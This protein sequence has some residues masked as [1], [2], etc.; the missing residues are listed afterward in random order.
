M[1]S[2]TAV[3]SLM[4]KLLKEVGFVQCP[5]EGVLQWSFSILNNLVMTELSNGIHNHL[6]PQEPAAGACLFGSHG[7]T[8]AGFE[9]VEEPVPLQP[10]LP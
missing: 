9:E 10:K 7:D 3:Q 8:V 1:V 5:A 4:D 2:I 6:L